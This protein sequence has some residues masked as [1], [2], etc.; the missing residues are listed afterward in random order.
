M[1]VFTLRHVEQKMKR[2]HYPFTHRGEITEVDFLH[3]MDGM[4]LLSVGN[5]G[6]MNLW[7]I[8]KDITKTFSSLSLIQA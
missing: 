8:T 2:I 5:D 1:I 7:D 3:S 4:Q 6:C